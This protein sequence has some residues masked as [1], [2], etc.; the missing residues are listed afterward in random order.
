MEA[1][2]IFA[3]GYKNNT[4]QS[5]KTIELIRGAGPKGIGWWEI[6]AHMALQ[7]KQKIGARPSLGILPWVEPSSLG[8][9]LNGMIIPLSTH[10]I[11]MENLELISINKHPVGFITLR[12]QIWEESG[13]ECWLDLQIKTEADKFIGLLSLLD[14]RMRNYPTII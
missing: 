12:K 10:R 9:R 3:Y 4:P 5:A 6:E 11:V 8:P 14:R 2:L 7:N 13:G 1:R